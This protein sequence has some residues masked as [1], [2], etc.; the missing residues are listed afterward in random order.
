MFYFG[1]YSFC[2]GVFYFDFTADSIVFVLFAYCFVFVYLLSFFRVLFI[3]LCYFVSAGSAV[4][5]LDCLDVV[6]AR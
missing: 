3:V 6:S 1:V 2:L 5:V 4:F